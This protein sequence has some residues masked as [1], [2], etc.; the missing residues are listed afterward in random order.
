MITLATARRI[1]GQLRSDPRTIALMVLVPTLIM[2]LLYYVID[3]EQAF[4]QW[5]PVLLS[6]FP[7]W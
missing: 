2:I 3:N 7:S 5:A 1:G 4:A 6:I